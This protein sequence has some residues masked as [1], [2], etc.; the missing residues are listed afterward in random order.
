MPLNTSPIRV[1]AGTCLIEC[2]FHKSKFDCS[3]GDVLVWSESV[4]G[5]PGTKIVGSLLGNINKGKKLDTYTV[6]VED[7]SILVDI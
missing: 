6:K 3:N 4:M 2:K 1:E 5:I 7:G